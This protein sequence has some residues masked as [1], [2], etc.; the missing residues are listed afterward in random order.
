[1]RQSRLFCEWE[2][3]VLDYWQSGLKA[4]EWCTLNGLSI[5]KLRYWIGKVNEISDAGKSGLAKTGDQKV[6]F[7]WAAVEI[8]DSN[9]S[10]GISICIGAAR[11]EVTSGFDKSLLSDVLQVVT[12]SC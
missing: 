1:M 5:H 10:S 9:K 2:P 7:G 6:G 11:I 4:V 12:R 8:V 3:R